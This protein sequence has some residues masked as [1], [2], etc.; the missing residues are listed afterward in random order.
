MSYGY[1]F[2]WL[3][4]ARCCGEPCVG[5]TRLETRVVADYVWSGMDFEELRRMWGGD[6]PLDHRAALVACWYEA[7]H[8]RHRRR[9]AAWREW[10]REAGEMLWQPSGQLP[11]PPP[12]R[13]SIAEESA[14]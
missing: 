14:A 4:P 1:P 12:A 10:A 11:G 7:R 3:D 13:R 5:G 9:K 8:G 6:E 2:V